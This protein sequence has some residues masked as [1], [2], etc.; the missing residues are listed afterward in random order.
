MFGKPQGGDALIVARETLHKQGV[1][2]NEKFVA[3][4][5]KILG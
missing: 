2:T 3:Q 4:K 5:A 1:L